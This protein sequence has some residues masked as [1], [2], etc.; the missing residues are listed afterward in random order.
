MRRLL[1]RAA[2]AQA[3]EQK[4]SMMDARSFVTGTGDVLRIGSGVDVRFR[5]RTAFASELEHTIT[6]AA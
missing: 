4:G 1:P 3:E 6:E 2:T 5:V